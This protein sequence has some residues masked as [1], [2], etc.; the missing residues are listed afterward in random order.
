MGAGSV[1]N[2][3]CYLD[4]RAGIV[5][6]KNVSISHNAKIYTMGHRINSASFEP[7]G[8]PCAIS[9]YSVVFSNAI[10]MPGVNLRKGCVVHA[11][12]VVTKSQ[13]AQSILGGG[14]RLSE[15][16]LEVLPV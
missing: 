7:Y 9:S 6:G 1:I 2:N 15:L 16:E 14:S 3:G 12:A 13:P 8:K 4:N 10:I 5:I 11:G